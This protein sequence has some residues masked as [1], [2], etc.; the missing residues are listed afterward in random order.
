[1]TNRKPRTTQKQKEKAPP[2]PPTKPR[3]RLDWDRWE[4]IV[5]IV[6]LILAVLTGLGAFN[7]S[8]GFLLSGWTTLLQA[9]LGWG[10]YFAP[11]LLL[12]LAVWLFADALNTTWNI[13]W[14]RPLGMG[15]LYFWLLAALHWIALPDTPLREPKVFS[16][17]G[18]IG[19][20]IASLIINAFGEIG[21]AL[22]LLAMAGIGLILLFNIS[23][24]E[25]I[26]RIV[27]LG[28]ILRHLP[29]E[30]EHYR[31][32]RSRQPIPPESQPIINYNRPGTSEPKINKPSTRRPKLPIAPPTPP[33]LPSTRPARAEPTQEEKPKVASEPMQPRGAVAARIIGGSSAAT[34]PAIQREWRLPDWQ[35]MLEENE[36][37]GIQREDVEKRYRKIE[38]TLAHFGVP[39][40]VHEVNQG[41]AIT[42]FGVEPGFIDQRGPDGK[43]NHVKVK[44]SRIVALQHDL[45]LALAAAPIR[46]EA[47]I[48]GK[49]MVGVEVPNEHIRSVSLREVMES[50]DF[51][52][53]K[54]KLRIALGQDVAGQP[55]S[56]DLTKM[57]HLLI[58]GATGSGKSVCV[59]AIIACLLCNTTPDEVKFIMIDPKRVEL[60]NFN[61]IDH[62]TRPVVVDMDQAVAA[63][64]GAVAE[65]DRRFKIFAKAGVR[66]IDIYHH[67][68]EG[69]PDAERL[70][71]LIVIVDELA[72]LMMISPDEV[73]KA[74]TRLAQMARATGIH[75]ILATQR[76]SVDV[77]TGLI[78]ANFPSRISFAVTSQIDSR[79]VLD[80]P[81]AEKLLGRGD[82]LYMASDSSK[83]VRL[84]GCFVSD[85]ELE[86]LVTY[87][88]DFAPPTPPAPTPESKKTGDELLQETLWGGTVPAKKSDADEDDLMPQAIDIVRQNHRASASLLQRKL[89]IGFQRA[90][91]LMELLE[92]KGIVGPDGGPTKGRPVIAQ[93]NAPSKPVASTAPPKRQFA[94]DADDDF[95]DWTDEDWEDLNK[96]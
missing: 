32:R 25:F 91:R 3:F 39:A 66:N 9:L 19:Y 47:P 94:E 29:Q 44:V 62:L 79:V 69:K 1:M 37:S 49:N 96:E 20:L 65:M 93:E 64:Q 73:E 61:G 10:V 75:L 58:A 21:A 72:D 80:T 15:L 31:T 42:Q 24:P 2:P 28:H 12:A 67:A 35:T 22:A 77:V 87:W 6:V 41:P 38:E 40:K 14:E 88:K 56:D 83:L 45:E 50:D 26:R 53:S 86:K 16:G 11:I 92:E 23:L 33:P 8:G 71:F 18:Y 17:G 82:M 27:Y 76:P 84:Q 60:V 46:I 57:P 78:K 95:D 85:R 34:A 4:E 70:P 68:I 52:K 63:L 54:S 59:N 30:L 36:E 74:I 55:V 5:A 7:L 13:G 51:K 48:P 81:G 90:A 43:V 89:R